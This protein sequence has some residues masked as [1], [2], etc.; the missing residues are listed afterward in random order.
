MVC[1]LNKVTV[2]KMCLVHTHTHTKS[3]KL[4]PPSDTVCLIKL[5]KFS[6]NE[7][8]LF[9]DLWEIIFSTNTLCFNTTATTVLR[10]FHLI[11]FLFN[12]SY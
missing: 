3:I 9:I 6:L 4:H 10:N 1:F 7:W 12:Q 11:T 2:L 8:K 5:G